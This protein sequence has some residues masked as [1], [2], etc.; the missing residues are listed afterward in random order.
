MLN[1]YDQADYSVCCSAVIKIS[2][3]NG[4]NFICCADGNPQTELSHDNTLSSTTQLP[5]AILKFL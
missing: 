3:N 5:L 4:Y 1:N 2:D